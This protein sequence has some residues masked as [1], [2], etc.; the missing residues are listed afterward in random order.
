[1][2]VRTPG[3]HHQ[4]DVAGALDPA[5]GTRFH[6]LGARHTKALCR[7]LRDVLEARYPA[8]PSIRLDV[9]VDHDQLHQAKAVEPWRAAHPRVTWLFGPT[10]GPRAHPIER[11]C[12]D[13]HDGCTR[14]HRRQRLPD[15]V[16]D[17][18]DHLHR[19]GPWPYQWS[20]LYDAPAVT[21]AVA[22]I[23]AAEYAKVAA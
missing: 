20:D 7:D 23:A 11:A 10:S 18:E 19:K 9:V 5:T 3:Q 21:A 16:A 22:K 4:P 8:E 2:A 14:N 6:G 13:G 15:L 1:V 17:G 12:G